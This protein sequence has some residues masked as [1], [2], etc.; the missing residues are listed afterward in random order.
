VNEIALRRGIL[1]SCR[2][3]LLCRCPL[4]IVPS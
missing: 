1:G 2:W 3:L 4:R